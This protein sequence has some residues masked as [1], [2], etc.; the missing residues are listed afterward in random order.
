MQ[1]LPSRVQRAVT[2]LAALL[3]IAASAPIARALPPESD[4]WLERRS[5]HFTFFGNGGEKPTVAI[6]TYFE[7]LRAAFAA[8]VPSVPL[9]T[10]PMDVYVFRDPASLGPYAAVRQGG[11]PTHPAGY[12][13]SAE[14][15]KLC[16][17]TAGDDRVSLEAAVRA[18]LTDVSATTFPSAPPW[19]Q[20]GLAE[21]Y[22]GLSA[23]DGKIEIGRP[24]PP[25]VLLLRRNPPIPVSKLF[26]M[27]KPTRNDGIIGAPSVFEAESWALMHYLLI[28][29]PEL[30]PKALRFLQA[31]AQGAPARAAFDDAFGATAVGELDAALRT[32][33]ARDSM[34]F[35][36]LPTSS[37]RV[38]APGDPV[39]LSRRDVLYRLGWL[40]ANID[41]SNASEAETH[42]RAALAIDPAHGPSLAGLGWIRSRAK[43]FNEAAPF[44]AQALAAGADDPMIAT[45]AGRNLL[46]Q[47][48]A[49][50]GTFEAP[51]AL[52][53][54]VAGARALLERA[55]AACPSCAEAHAA[56]GATY[57]YDPGDVA[58]GIAE[59]DTALTLAPPRADPLL[60]LVSL[61]AR[62]GDRAKAQAVVD[63]PIVALDD[64][65]ALSSARERLAFSDLAAINAK[66]AAGDLDG[67]LAI[68]TAARDAATTPRLRAQFESEIARIAPVALKNQQVARFNEAVNLANAGDWNGAGALCDALL[69]ETLDD[70]LRPRIEDL[71]ARAT[72]ASAPKVKKPK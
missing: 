62:R 69:K 45:M 5:Q 17:I 28:G 26:T 30:R 43:K 52:S 42:F 33:V 3:A 70:Q 64:P 12:Y 18:Y 20:A 41:E 11:D 54:S 58:P 31:L 37:I 72:A 7:T 15:V 24:V 34:A 21:L 71:R 35:F 2:T 61:H 1:P 25:F 29:E 60:N 68:L 23:V 10:A 9:R 8:L 39:P 63:G 32:Y 46:A 14:Y 55:V 65:V 19:V 6:A 53:E 4:R 57:L 66:I 40:L 38:T 67:A 13:R 27:T 16:A 44:F 36:A 50:R 22:A 47:Y 51:K 48:G 49:E 56:L 59:I